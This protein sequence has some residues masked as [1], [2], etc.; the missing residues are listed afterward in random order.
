[1]RAKFSGAIE[2]L[3]DNAGVIGEAAHDR[4]IDFDEIGQP[5]LRRVCLTS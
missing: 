2:D 1:M 3:E 5:A 4:E